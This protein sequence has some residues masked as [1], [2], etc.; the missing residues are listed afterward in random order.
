MKKVLA[1]LLAATLSIS[2]LSGCAG[3]DDKTIKVGASPTPH[4][5][6]LKQAAPLLEAKGY[7]L[8][9]QEFNDYVLPNTAVN[10]GE[11]DANYFQHITYLENFNVEQGRKN[12]RTTNK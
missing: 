2:L 6:I 3:S 7:Q 9:I 8:E 4:A 11:L 10:D 1:F 12:N 5:E